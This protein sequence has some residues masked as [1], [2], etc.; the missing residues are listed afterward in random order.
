M[1]VFLVLGGFRENG[2]SSGNLLF[3]KT[4]LLSTYK[5]EYL[6]MLDALKALLKS[7]GISLS[8]GKAKTVKSQI[9]SKHVRSAS[10][11]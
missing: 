8:N 11:A 10:V 3:I 1:F 5:N 4:N 2:F 7:A 6:C 9:A